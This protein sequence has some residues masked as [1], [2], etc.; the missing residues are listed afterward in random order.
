MV[1][2][3]SFT[4]VPISL[5]SYKVGKKGFFVS[6]D[7]LNALFMLIKHWTNDKG[8]QLEREETHCC[9]FVGYSFQ[10]TAWDLLDAPSYRLYSTV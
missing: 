6:N 8:P 1:T 10:L 7:L 4:S 9:H 2:T 3:T 5:L